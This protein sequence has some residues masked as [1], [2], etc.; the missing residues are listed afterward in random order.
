ME[1]CNMDVEGL[2]LPSILY[3]NVKLVVI[4]RYQNLKVT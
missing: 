4:Q 3:Q 1:G 2:S